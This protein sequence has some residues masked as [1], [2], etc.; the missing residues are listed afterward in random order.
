MSRMPNEILAHE[1]GWQDFDMGLKSVPQTKYIRADRV[2][3]L[4]NVLEEISNG[5]G[6]EQDNMRYAKQVL[7]EFKK[8]EG[9]E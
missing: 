2:E 5:W 4:L 8:N 9:E 3:P 6:C 1:E 7:L